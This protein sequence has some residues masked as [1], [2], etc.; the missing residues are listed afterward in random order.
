ME[1]MRTTCGFSL[2]QAQ[3]NSL[4]K[5][6]SLELKTEDAVEIDEHDSVVLPVLQVKEETEEAQLGVNEGTGKFCLREELELE[7]RKLV[8]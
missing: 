6:L 4:E 3:R 1:L 7:F 2:T 5:D 8:R